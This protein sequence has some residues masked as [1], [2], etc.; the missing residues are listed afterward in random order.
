[1]AIEMMDFPIKHGDFPVMWLWIQRVAC[2][3]IGRFPV[4]VKVR[5][6][7]T[8]LDLALEKDWHFNVR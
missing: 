7:D 5:M 8:P 6:A 3:N 4:I 1:M 2:P